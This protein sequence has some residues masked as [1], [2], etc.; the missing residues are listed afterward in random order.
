MLKPCLTCGRLSH[1]SRCADHRI[2]RSS[3][4]ARGY[5]SV[6]Q[7]QAK[8]QI[9]AVP[10]CQCIGCGIHAGPCQSTA[11]L[12]ADHVIPKARGGT[13]DHGLQTL[14]RRCNSSKK[15]RAR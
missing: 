14:C 15:D 6:W 11:D 8:A 1:W 5:G 2:K 4:T 13:A 3:A 7:R 9:A 10:W 12:T